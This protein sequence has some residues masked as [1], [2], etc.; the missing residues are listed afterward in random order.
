MKESL[1]VSHGLTALHKVSRRAGSSEMKG[2]NGEMELDKFGN[3]W[4][5]S[6]CWLQVITSETPDWMLTGWLW[7][8]TPG[9]LLTHI[10]STIPLH[11]EGLQSQPQSLSQQLNCGSETM[12]RLHTEEKCTGAAPGPNLPVDLI[13]PSHYPCSQKMLPVSSSMCSV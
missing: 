1:A 3:C 9:N 4:R 11:S 13:K 12:G 10:S 7:P 6:S 8:E 5:L 2:I